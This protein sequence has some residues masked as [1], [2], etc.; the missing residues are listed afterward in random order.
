MGSLLKGDKVG[1][2]DLRRRESFDRKHI[3]H[4]LHI[5]GLQGLYSRFSW[6]P[7]PKRENRLGAAAPLLA[8]CYREDEKELRSLLSRWNVI[9]V[10]HADDDVFW[11]KA[12]QED[13]VVK[14]SKED[15]PTLLFE[16]SPLVELAVSACEKDQKHSSTYTVIDLGCGAGRDIAWIVRKSKATWLATGLDN[17]YATIQRA[18]LLRDDFNLGQE[19]KSRIE[20][21][22][23]AQATEIGTLEALQFG[24]NH[25][26]SRGVKIDQLPVVNGDS[27][28]R[29]FASAHL[30]QTTYDLILLVRFF[31]R[32]LLFQLPQLSHNGTIIAISHFTTLAEETDYSSPDQSKRFE[33]QDVT[34]LLQH[35]GVHEWRLLHHVIH[36]AEDGR[37][38]QSVLFQKII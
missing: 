24:S 25:S 7:P 30:P 3:R 35:W 23:W 26:K 9:K 31:P 29:A 32:S 1:V 5:P 8:I 13:L 11:N 27:S 33:E 14:L 10:I 21:L 38:L 18:T 6:L 37:P 36:R 20:S 34:K 2:I 22:V 12:K 28:L 17:L 4:S 15:E 19:G 16:P